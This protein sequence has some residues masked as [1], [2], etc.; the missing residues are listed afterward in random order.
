M[1][2]SAQIR[3]GR[4]LLGLTVGE[5]SVVCGLD[6]D[7][8]SAIEQVSATPSDTIQ[9]EML[10]RTLEELGVS[11]LSDGDLVLGGPGVR[12]TD[13]SPISDGTRPENLSA[14]NDG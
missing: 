6:T 1:I 2:N 14:A 5:L 8:I 12:L 13:R 7:T 3:A 9:L 10:R 4:A 11:F